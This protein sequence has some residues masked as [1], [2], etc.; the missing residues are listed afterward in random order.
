[1]KPDSPIFKK[2][3]E[4]FIGSGNYA[5]SIVVG[6]V[7]LGKKYLLFEVDAVAI[8]KKTCIKKQLD[9]KTLT[10]LL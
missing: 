9:L 4:D 2:V 8:I 7:V 10:V 1:M 3:C 5:A 6:V